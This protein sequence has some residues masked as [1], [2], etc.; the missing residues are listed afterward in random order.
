MLE[1]GLP[2]AAGTDA[3]RVASYNPWVCL[4]WL[5]SGKT[6]AGTRIHPRRNAL[7]RETAL[8]LWT[9]AAGWFSRE[10]GRKG[11]LAEG[12]LADIAVLS[13]DYLG[14]PEDEIA[15]IASVLTLVGGKV[16]H[17]SDEF[18]TLAPP[19][20]PAMP[21]WSPVR[22]YGGYQ[23]ARPRVH[24][25][26]HSVLRVRHACRG[27]FGARGA[28]DAAAASGMWATMACGCAGP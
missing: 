1:M 5:V 24:S 7:D 8:R 26:A 20:P 21:D 3:T 10:E 4:A 25:P 17:A 19:L 27:L 2:V 9:D 22:H 11:R 12:R 15:D 28:A 16:V 13:A 6:V 18:R 14:V 23:H